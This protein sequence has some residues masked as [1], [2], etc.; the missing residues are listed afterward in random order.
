MAGTDAAPLAAPS[1]GAW[2]HYAVAVNA[3]GSVQAYG[4]GLPLATVPSALAASMPTN[5]PLTFGHAADAA[6]AVKTFSDVLD[7]VRVE[8]VPRSADWIR[9]AYMTQ[10]ENGLFTSYNRWGSIMFLR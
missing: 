9:A 1:T 7:E 3:N 2:A 4:N 10:A 5:Q 6:D 8:S